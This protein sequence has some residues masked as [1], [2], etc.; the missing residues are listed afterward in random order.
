MKTAIR[1]LAVVLPLLLSACL[2]K[3]PIFTT[4]FIKTDDAITGIWLADEDKDKPDDKK[5]FAAVFKIDDDQYLL[6]YPTLPKD[7]FYYSMKPLKIRDRLVLQVRAIASAKGEVPVPGKDEAYTLIWVEKNSDTKLTVRAL[8]G[9]LE[10]K[11]PAEVSKLI[12]DPAGDWTP[13]FGDPMVFER[14]NKR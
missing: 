2:F 6:H 12:E 9:N 13:L 3:E 5:P 4:G 10:K 1:L 7:G 14:T 8:L 11:T